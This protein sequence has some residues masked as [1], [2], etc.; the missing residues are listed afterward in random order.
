MSAMLSAIA[1]ARIKARRRER[2]MRDRRTRGDFVEA[3][4]RELLWVNYDA[5]RPIERA[6][7]E[8]LVRALRRRRSAGGFSYGRAAAAIR[9]VAC[10]IA[11]P[12]D[13]TGFCSTS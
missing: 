2:E 9:R 10:G 3:L 11:L 4:S 13:P 1:Y 12:A 5:R 6:I 7:E 8:A